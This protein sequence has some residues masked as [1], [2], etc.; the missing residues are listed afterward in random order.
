MTFAVVVCNLAKSLAEENKYSGEPDFS[1][2]VV[3]AT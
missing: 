3:F 2:R 1:S